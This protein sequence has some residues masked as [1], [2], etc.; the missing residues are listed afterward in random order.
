MSK[1][2]VIYIDTDDDITAL[3]DHVVSAKSKIV[4]LVLP[5]RFTLLQSAVNMKLLKRSAD[6]EKKQVVIITK[7]KNL[8]PLAGVAGLYV[9]ENLKTRPT[10]P[11]VSPTIGPDT[12][13]I[14]AIDSEEPLDLNTTVGDLDSAHKSTAKSSD[15]SKQGRVGA[16]LAKIPVLGRFVHSEER[17]ETESSKDRSRVAV[18]NFQRFRMRIVLIVVALIAVG[19]AWVFAFVVL[20]KATVAIIART[21]DVPTEV[22]ATINSKLEKSDF[23]KLAIK[24]ERQTIQR[25][26]SESFPATGEKDI[27]E[28]A[29]G[30]ISLENCYASFTVEVPAGT[31]MT[32][33]TS[34]I[35]FITTS[36]VEVG[37]AQFNNGCVQPGRADVSVQA[38]NSG[39]DKN[40]SPR[41]YS[42]E[43]FD[44]MTAFG[45]Q[46]SGGTTQIVKVISPADIETATDKLLAKEDDS[47]LAELRAEFPQ[48]V[49]VI[50]ESF[51]ANNDAPVAEPEVDTQVDEGRV[52]ARF[53]YAMLGVARQELEQL[54]ES[55]QNEQIDAGEEVIL[56]NGYDE[57]VATVL[58]TSAATKLEVQFTTKAFAGPEIDTQALAEE[59]SGKRYGEVERILKNKSGV[60]EVDITFSPPWVFVAPKA[61]RI[62]IDVEVVSQATNSE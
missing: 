9:S 60:R 43:E 17:D 57:L 38:K 2:D 21:T 1:K 18:P 61:S 46:M 62:T 13:I 48:N 19:V 14:Q 29:T 51:T 10:I 33:N 50:E 11:D 6:S 16:T 22:T 27:G 31:E 44:S 30:L 37:P 12:S 59:I 36:A 56:D 34:G 5:K 55:Y 35:T 20:P 47:V 25:T 24:A 58:K 7:D 42:V 52:T 15:G 53:T 3:I 8:L 28:K 45:S 32:D 23:E 49:F 4:A 41:S 26:I 39:D 54:L 40:L